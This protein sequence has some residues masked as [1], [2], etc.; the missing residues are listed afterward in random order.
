MEMPKEEQNLVELITFGVIDVRKQ[1]VSWHKP[2]SY[3]KRIKML[4]FPI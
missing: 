3:I 2:V 1:N 4:L